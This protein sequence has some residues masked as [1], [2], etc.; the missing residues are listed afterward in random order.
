MLLSI[1]AHKCCSYN[2]NCP[3]NYQ[4]L[5]SN[6]ELCEK[7]QGHSGNRMWMMEDE[8]KYRNPVEMK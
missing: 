3:E 6:I 4:S 7:N 5:T 8:Y 2:R 1:S